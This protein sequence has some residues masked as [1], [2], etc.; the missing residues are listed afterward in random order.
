MLRSAS[1]S[2]ALPLSR[3]ARS[4][5]LRPLS[6]SP[7]RLARPPT[8]TTPEPDAPAPH[9][10]NQQ[11]QQHDPSTPLPPLPPTNLPVEDYAS[12]L[13]HTA[14]FFSSLFRYAVFGSVA[15]VS[16]SVGGLVAVHLYVEHVQLAPP[17]LAL[18]ADDD[19]EEWAEELEGW[20]GAH[21][22]NGGT[23]PRLGL[24]ARAA[25]RGAWIS[26]HWG[27]GLVAAPTATHAPATAPAASSSSSSSPF[28]ALA[29]PGGQMI[30]HQ[31]EV[32]SRGRQ[33][34]DAGWAMA[35]RYLVFAL[36]KAAKRGV[37]LV[38]SVDWEAHVEHGGVD[39][40]AVELEERL[41]GLRERIGGRYKLEAAREGWERIYY[42]VA[43]SPTTDRATERGRREAEWERREKLKASRKLGEL[44]ARIAELWR[45]GSDE[46]LVE[47][48]KAEGWFVGGLVPVLA[49][50]E[51]RSLKGKALDDLV[52]AAASEPKA[53]KHA[54]PSSSFFGFWSR[55]HPPSSPSPSSPSPSGDLTPELAHLVA[56]VPSSASS[57][58]SLAPLPPSTSRAI[59]SSLVSLETFLARRRDSSTLSS[60]SP[61]S[62]SSAPLAHL[63]AAAALQR[64]TI[65][66][67]EGLIASSSSSSAF[68]AS[69]TPAAADTPATLSR[70]LSHLFYLTR[71][72][73]L[74]TH[75]AECGVAL[76]VGAS[77]KRRRGGGV[78]TQDVDAAL[79]RLKRAEGAAAQVLAAVQGEGVLAQLSQEDEG[80]GKKKAAGGGE[81]GKLFGEQAKRVRRDAEKVRGIAEGLRGVVE[82][83]GG[84]GQKK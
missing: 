13:L 51:G 31:D 16:L 33:V 20:S 65:A 67:A 68:P 79:E 71:L 46:R 6:S 82:G 45:E 32:A 62:S 66:F 74:E 75:L 17:K 78:A 61:T 81:V 83:L 26:Q 57:S 10:A 53:T 52:P 21:T 69:S 30:G 58:T 28:G 25:V 56:L 47:N 4:L 55:S 5:A 37:S 64:A 1:R 3:R 49:E 40:A 18:S 38:D 70:T 34:S 11:Q 63:S 73:A 8:F 60:A 27:G 12:P 29:R 48:R 22:G 59:L 77:S 76:S 23:D 7:I 42:A 2:L 9:P 15:L 84:A 19:P 54:S 39:R 35:E 14:S 41:A 80:K 50:E 44:S 24:V 72:A 43:A 36:D